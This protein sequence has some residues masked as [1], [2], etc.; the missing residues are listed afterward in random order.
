VGDSCLRRSRT[1][2]IGG[3]WDRSTLDKVMRERFMMRVGI[4]YMVATDVFSVWI[5]LSDTRIRIAI[6]P[7]FQPNDLSAKAAKIH[8]V[9]RCPIGTD[10]SLTR[11]CWKHRKLAFCWKGKSRMGVEWK[12]VK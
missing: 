10:G 7:G 8:V 9:I 2:K 6:S 1:N 11:Y 3:A 5:G 4:R 12:A